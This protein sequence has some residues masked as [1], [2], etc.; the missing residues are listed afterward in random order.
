MSTITRLGLL[1]GSILVA[2]YFLLKVRKGK[3]EINHILYWIFFSIML[4]FM[5]AFPQ[6]PIWLA[7]KLGF[8]SPINFV[9]MVIIFL[10]LIK[11]FLMSID[12]ANLENKIK[13]LS[14]RI[15]IDKNESEKK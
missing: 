4:L 1:V 12:M 7:V 11:I 14:Q 6:V 2:I 3:I 8:V 9:F 13:T 15:A 5:A 10:L